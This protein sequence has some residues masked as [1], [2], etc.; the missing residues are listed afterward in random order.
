[1]I[2]PNSEQT[3]SSKRENKGGKISWNQYQGSKDS[4]EIQVT[5]MNIKDTKTGDHY[6]YNTK[7]GRSGVALGGAERS[8]QKK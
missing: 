8:G 3:T 1:M 7:Q 2:K 4:R 6:F 5:Q